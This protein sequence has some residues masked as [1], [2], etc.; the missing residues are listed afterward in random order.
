MAIRRIKKSVIHL[1]TDFAAIAL[2]AQDPAVRW[3]RHHTTSWLMPFG[4]S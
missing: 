3:N 2:A 4:R 1:I